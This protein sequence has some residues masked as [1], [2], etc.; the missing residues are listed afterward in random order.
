MAACDVRPPWSVTIA[1]ARFM[2][3]TQSGSVVAATSTDA[4]DEALDIARAFEQ[5]NAAG[6]DR[7]ADAEA[8]GQLAAPSGFDPIGP[9]AQPASRRDWTVSGRA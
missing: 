2:I 6:H 1:A 3:G 4:V 7:V 8:G 5:A 9:Q